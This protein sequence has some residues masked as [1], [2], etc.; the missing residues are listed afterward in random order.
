ML[1]GGGDEAGRAEMGGRG[2]TAAPVAA[3][4]WRQEERGKRRGHR[5]LDG[6]SASWAAAACWFTWANFPASGFQPKHDE[7]L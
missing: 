3:V 5:D 7:L 4:R 6:P 2:D 1:E